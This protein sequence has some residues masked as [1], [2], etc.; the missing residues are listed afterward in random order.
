MDKLS[1]LTTRKRGKWI[2]RGNHCFC[3]ECLTVGS[4]MWRACPACTAIM[5]APNVTDQ[6]KSAIEKMGRQAHGEE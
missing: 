5:D 6:T 1:E 2:V 4:P 3:S